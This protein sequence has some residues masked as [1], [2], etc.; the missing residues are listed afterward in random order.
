MSGEKW[1]VVERKGG[2]RE[3][4]EVK[5]GAEKREDENV[6]VYICDCRIGRE[7]KWVNGSSRESPG[8]A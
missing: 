7:Q 2:E 8:R 5:G 3:T 1:F 6:C 4:E